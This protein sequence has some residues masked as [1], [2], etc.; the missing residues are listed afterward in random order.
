MM[1]N[2][3]SSYDELVQS[4][5]K[6]MREDI[7]KFNKAITDELENLKSYLNDEAKRI[8]DKFENYESS[9]TVIRRDKEKIWAQKLSDFAAICVQSQTLKDEMILRFRNI[10]EDL[11]NSFGKNYNSQKNLNVIKNA[12]NFTLT[13]KLC[14]FSNLSSMNNVVYQIKAKPKVIEQPINIAPI[15]SNNILPPREDNFLLGKKHKADEISVENCTGPKPKTKIMIS[16]F[17][18]KK[19]HNAY[20]NFVNGNRSKFK[21]KHPY[22][23]HFELSKIMGEEWRMMEDY[24]KKQYYNNSILDKSRYE[25]ELKSHKEVVEEIVNFF[26]KKETVMAPFHKKRILESESEESINEKK[27]YKTS[28]S[29]ESDY[30]FYK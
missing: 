15:I 1:P 19:C 22:L 24:T 6:R 28:E 26:K 9:L 18:P 10:R 16:K 25:L 7:S 8:K 14:K 3:N 11:K 2:E 20:V 17:M 4:S 27:E 12:E 21:E 30:Y 13:P 5:E 23:N 29:E